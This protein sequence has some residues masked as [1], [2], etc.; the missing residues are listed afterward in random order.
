LIRFQQHI[1]TEKLWGLFLVLLFFS[2]CKTLTETSKYGFNEGYYKSRLYHKKLKNVYVVSAEDS[3]KIYSAKSI[4]KGFVDTA[5]KTKLVFPVNKKPLNFEN[6]SFKKNSFDLDALSILFKYRP[7]VKNFPRQLNTGFNGA[8]YFGYRT[9]M[10][11]L[12]YKQTPL[13]EYKRNI[14]HYGYSIGAFSGIGTARIDPFV[15]LNGIDYEYD[16]VVNLTGIAVIAGVNK[17]SLGITS[18]VDF[19]LDKNRKY[20]VNN[21]KPWIGI[22]IGLNIN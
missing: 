11:R 15:T 13:K 6:Y 7:S 18:G 14:N 16:G 2:S 22:A 1:R 8:V 5:K 3:I 9:D 17:L 20:W 19:L 21:K 10:Y 12:S 4:E